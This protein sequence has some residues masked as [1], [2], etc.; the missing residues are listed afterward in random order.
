MVINAS[1]KPGFWVN[2]GVQ[3]PFMAAIPPISLISDQ[4]DPA[5]PGGR[6]GRR[7]ARDRALGQKNLIQRSALG[8]AEGF[9]RCACRPPLAGRI[10]EGTIKTAFS[11]RVDL[12]AGR[13]WR[14]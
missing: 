11:A 13:W 6:D 1:P 7:S 14:V 2:L 9:T 12:P 10:I 3:I 4:D 8:L 5:K